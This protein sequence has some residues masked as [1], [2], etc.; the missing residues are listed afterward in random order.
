MANG[1]NVHWL[2]QRIASAVVAAVLWIAAVSSASPQVPLQQ[3]ER[4]ALNNLQHEM[5]TCV[6]FYGII[7]QCL[8]NRGRSEDA[9]VIQQTTAAGDQVLKDAMKIGTSIG[10]TQD[11]MASRIRNE[12]TSM[13]TLMNED[14]INVSS[15]LSR[16]AMRCK[17]VAENPDSVLAEYLQGR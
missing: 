14:C 6:V 5:T 2:S 7:R 12:M 1:G 13:R 3:S 16:H 9:Q 15:L 10:M 8:I 17:Q 11:A 4:Q